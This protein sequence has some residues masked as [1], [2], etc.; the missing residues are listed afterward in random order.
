MQVITMKDLPTEEQA[1]V[2]LWKVS[3]QKNVSGK[4]SHGKSRH[5]SGR[6]CAAKWG[7]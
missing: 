3:E 1:S 2:S 5:S 7:F 4:N 6:T